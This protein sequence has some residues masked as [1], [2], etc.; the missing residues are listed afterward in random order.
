MAIGSEHLAQEESR[1]QQFFDSEDNL[2]NLRWRLVQGL[3][4][5][6]IELDNHELQAH[7]R[8]TVVNQVAIDQP[9]YAGFK[10]ATEDG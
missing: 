3:R 8:Q 1:L 2:F 10:Q 4:D 9:G 7:L 5:G 6:S